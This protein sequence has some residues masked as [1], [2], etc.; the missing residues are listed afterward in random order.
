MK[1]TLAAIGYSGEFAKFLS[2]YSSEILKQNG[3]SEEQIRLPQFYRAMTGKK[4][5][6]ADNSLNS[7][8]FSIYFVH[9]AQC[10]TSVY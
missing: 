8:A 5:R 3:I 7:I 2:K 1:E 9:D 4:S 6:F 10:F